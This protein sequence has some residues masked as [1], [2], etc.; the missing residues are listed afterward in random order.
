M[1]SIDKRPSGKY[2]AR[3]REYPGGPQRTKTFARKV[4]AERFLVDVQHRLLSGTYVDPGVSRTTLDAYAEVHLAR[5][6]WRASTGEVAARALTHAGRELG[7]RPLGSIRKGD[8]QAFVSGLEL[9][10]ST[11]ATTFQHLNTLLE[12]AVDDGLI[13]RNPARG[14][15]LPGRAVGEVVP[16][17]TEQVAALHEAAPTWF[18]PAVILGAGVG[19]RQAEA[20]GL[21]VDRVLWLERS[22]RVDRQWIT[23]SGLAEFGPPKSKSSNR[24]IPAS[25]FVLDELAGHVGRRHDGFVVHRDAEPVSYHA[26]GHYWRRTTM[27]A[28][29]GQWV[30]DPDTGRKRWQG[31]RYHD[32]RHAFASMLIAEGCSVKAVQ[33]A[34]GHATAAT[35]LNLYAH[36]WPGDEDRIRQAVDHALARA[37][38]D[39]LRTSGTTDRA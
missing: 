9:A 13:A 25:T 15:K 7:R 10:P 14:V 4:D 19:L 20:S 6:P 28:G 18:R 31:M 12:A 22:V 38:E 39:Q 3:W 33:H 32:L 5:Q 17:T 24:T 35:T 2:L 1:A 26:F 29:L 37:A 16:P 30:R 27:G 21:T 11:V 36:L 23:R 8:V 34:L